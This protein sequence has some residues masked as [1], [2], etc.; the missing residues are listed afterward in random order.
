MKKRFKKA[1]SLI[2]TF[3]MCIVFTPNKFTLTTNAAAISAEE[4]ARKFEELKAKYPTGTTW[5]G[6]YMNAS[7]CIGFA[8]LVD[9]YLF[10]ECA[11]SF[12]NIS[13]HFSFHQN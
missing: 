9:D 1:I 4:M 10:N 2:L 11:P 12:S 5:N 3:A 6:T 7:Q 13:R 8:F